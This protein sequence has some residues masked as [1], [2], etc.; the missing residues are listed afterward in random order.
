MNCETFYNAI[1]RRP[2]LIEI[3]AAISLHQLL[4]KFLTDHGTAK[5]K[6]DQIMAKECYISTLHDK[7]SSIAWV[8]VVKEELQ[9]VRSEPTDAMEEVV[10]QVE[11]R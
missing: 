3:K 6:G 4:I 1:I 9:K 7:A 11:P 5:V 8:G 2:S 10:V